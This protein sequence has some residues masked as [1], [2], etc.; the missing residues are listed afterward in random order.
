MTYNLKF[1]LTTRLNRVSLFKGKIIK[2]TIRDFSF[3][4]KKNMKAI[5]LKL[6]KFL[7]DIVFNQS[8]TSFTKTFNRTFFLYVTCCFTIRQT[9]TRKIQLKN[10]CILEVQSETKFIVSSFDG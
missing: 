6:A 2:H 8:T 9:E 7:I 1:I 5:N 10:G 3:V 4:F